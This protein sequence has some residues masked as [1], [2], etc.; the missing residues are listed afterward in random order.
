M[1]Q[2]A[3]IDSQMHA[4]RLI[5]ANRLGVPETNPP[6]FFFANLRGREWGVGSVGVEAAFLGGAPPIFSPEAPQN[7][8]FEGFSERF[9]AKIS[10]R[11]ENADPT[12]TDPMPYSR[13][14]ENRESAGLR[15]FARSAEKS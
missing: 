15:R 8:Y 14:S 7:P 12:T 11:P 1:A 10:P 9:G 4:K 2:F 5:R 3:R 13:P 6:L